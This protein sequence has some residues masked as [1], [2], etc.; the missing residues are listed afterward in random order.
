MEELL[1]AIVTLYNYRL[2]IEAFDIASSDVYGNPPLSASAPQHLDAS[3]VSKVEK[4]VT[5]QLSRAGVRLAFFLNQA[6]GTENTDWDTCL[7]GKV[8]AKQVAKKKHRRHR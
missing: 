5:L 7:K 8:Q 1:A 4:D 3:Y 6:F 2:A